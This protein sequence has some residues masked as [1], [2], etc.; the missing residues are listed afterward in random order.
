MVL[1]SRLCHL[2]VEDLQWRTHQ[3]LCEHAIRSPLSHTVQTRR[4]CA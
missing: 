3:H 2:P 4:R 1:Q